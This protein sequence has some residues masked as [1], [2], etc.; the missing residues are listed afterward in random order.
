MNGTIWNP[1]TPVSNTINPVAPVPFVKGTVALPGITWVGDTD[2]GIYSDTDGAM[3]ITTNGVRKLKIDA[4]GLVTVDKTLKLA[5]ELAV[6]SAATVDLGNVGSNVVAI[7]GNIGISSFGANF[8]GPVFLRFTDTL[9]LQNSPSLMIP[10]GANITVNA[11]DTAIVVPTAGGWTVV[12]FI[13]SNG[14]PLITAGDLSNSIR[15]DIASVATPDLTAFSPVTRNINITGTVNIIGFTISAGSLFFARFAGVLTLTNGAALQIQSGAN[16]TTAAGDTCI[17]RAIAANTV[18]VL[19]YTAGS[20]RA[21]PD[22]TGNSSKVVGTADGAN[23]T[24]VDGLLP[25][26]EM[27]WPTEVPP[28]G[29]LEEDGSSLLRAGTYAALFAVIGTTYGTADATHFNLPDARGRFLRGWAHGSANDPDRATR[30]VPAV[31]GTTMAAGDHVGTYQVDGFKAHT[32]TYNDSGAAGATGRAFAADNLYASV[33]S[34]STG[35]N[36]T[37]PINTTR[38]VIIKY[39]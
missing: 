31:A 15:Q 21:L 10:S 26:M 7:T 17:I 18:E 8:N 39:R 37:R 36:E 11:N 5:A 28:V 9:I 13:R 4:A 32:H 29:W 27:M 19:C 25:G 2:T 30:T 22:P 3:C 1:G 16:I 14:G 35:G 24:F 12:S 38:M 20:S 23:I 6:A 34:G 33:N